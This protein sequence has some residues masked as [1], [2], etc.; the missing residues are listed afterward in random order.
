MENN[1]I[2]ELDKIIQL[3]DSLSNAFGLVTIEERNEEYTKR[4]GYSI[5]KK[6]L[7]DTYSLKKY[8][9]DKLGI[10]IYTLFD[11]I[12]NDYKLPKSSPKI[13]MNN[14]INNNSGR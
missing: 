8:F 7:D 13:N 6:A 12:P 14:V 3:S 1:P 9:D 11:E 2:N 5:P 10:D 4:R